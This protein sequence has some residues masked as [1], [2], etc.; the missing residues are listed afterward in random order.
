MNDKPAKQMK[1]FAVM[2]KEEV[3]R[4]ASLGGQSVPPEERIFFKNR[5]LAAEAGAKGGKAGKKGRA[6]RNMP[7]EVTP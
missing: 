7:S 4:I 1:G 3:R 5:T 2:D 6:R